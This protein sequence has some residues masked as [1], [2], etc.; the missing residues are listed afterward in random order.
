M[1]VTDAGLA[2]AWSDGPHR[3]TLEGS[4]ATGTATTTN[5]QYGHSLGE[6]VTA[7][8]GAGLRVVRLDEHLDADV[9]APG[10][11]SVQDPNGRWRMHLGGQDVPVFFTLI[12]ER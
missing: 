1:M 5:V 3:F 8:A 4:Y 11:G 6:I 12:A 2:R 7:T 9:R 10:M